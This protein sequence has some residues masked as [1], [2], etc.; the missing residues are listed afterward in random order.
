MNSNQVNQLKR[1][2]KKHGIRN[3]ETTVRTAIDMNYA[4]FLELAEPIY[5][6]SRIQSCYAGDR[7]KELLKMANIEWMGLVIENGWC[8]QLA[9]YIQK[10][11]TSITEKAIVYLI[12]KNIW[13]SYRGKDYLRVKANDHYKGLNDIDEAAEFVKEQIYGSEEEQP[14]NNAGKEDQPEEK[15]EHPDAAYEACERIFDKFNSMSEDFALVKDFIVMNCENN[16]YRKAMDELK[17]RVEVLQSVKDRQEKELAEK[18]NSINDLQLTIA[19]KNDELT[20]LENSNIS[21]AAEK[22]ALLSANSKL[23]DELEEIKSLVDRL[24]KESETIREE[25]PKKKVIPESGLRELP[26]VGDKMLRGLAPFLE[27]YNIIIDP[28]K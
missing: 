16:D 25:K 21:L 6:I 22:L 26:L 13:D 10:Y 5:V 14:S 9:P 3:S 18:R 4:K 23:K 12:E 11:G 8:T 28:S 20:D 15:K 24:K 2:L 1:V 19:G 17:S 27:K 7:E